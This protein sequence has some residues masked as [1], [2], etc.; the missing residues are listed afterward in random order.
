MIDQIFSD[1]MGYF[2]PERVQNLVAAGAV[3]VVGLVAMR[4]LT[5]F[6]RR[7]SR[8]N[9]TPQYAMLIRKGIKYVIGAIVLFIVLHLLGVKIG[10]LLGAA[11]IVGIAIGFASQT[12]MSNL[13]SGLFLIS[14]KPFEIGDVIRVGGTSGVIQSIDLLSVKIKTFDNQYIRIPNEKLLNS[15]LTNVTR[16]PIRRLDVQLSVAYKTD[17]GRLREVLLDIAAKNP[18]CLDEPEPLVVFTEFGDSAL[19]FL[20]GVWFHKT[21]Y[22]T[23][24]NSV[25]QEIKERFEQEGIEIPFPHLSLYAGSATEPLPVT[26]TEGGRGSQRGGG[27]VSKS[28]RR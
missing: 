8:R 21:D 10:A 12:S 23:L 24:K 1:F 26:L 4:L 16:F 18:H 6:A 13:I 9:V 7:L 14:E 2:T 11:G 25:M 22:L 27:A 20:F 28:G 17:V 3:I 19:K 5:G 15:E